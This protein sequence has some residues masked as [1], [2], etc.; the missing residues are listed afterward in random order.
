MPSNLRKYLPSASEE[1]L[2]TFF[3][4]IVSIVEL[5]ANDPTRVGVIRAYSE[6]MRILII[7]ALVFGQSPLTT[8]VSADGV[9]QGLY[10]SLSHSL[11]PISAWEMDRTRW[12]DW[13]LLV[14]ALKSRRRK[15]T[16][17]QRGPS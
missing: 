9:L 1:E 8:G 15:R 17:R 12:M 11:C 6:T 4:S 7:V 16:K 3:G 13:I 14:G 5:E 10:Q 2:Q